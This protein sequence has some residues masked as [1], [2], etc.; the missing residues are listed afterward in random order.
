MMRNVNMFGEAFTH[1]AVY[2]CGGHSV[3]DLFTTFKKFHDDTRTGGRRSHVGFETFKM[4][5][6]VL[7]IRGETKCGLSS[8]YIH[9]R[10]QTQVFVHMMGRVGVI[11]PHFL[12]QAK[13]LVEEW[14][15][16]TCFVMWE[17]SKKHITLD[18]LDPC[19]CSRYGLGG[20]CDDAM[21]SHNSVGCEKCSSCITFFTTKV[22]IFLSILIQT[23]SQ[24][25][26]SSFDKM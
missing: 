21:H 16:M 2:E 25:N 17:Y 6:K 3:E 15:T 5:M 20:S 23:S 10:Y 22:N 1:L 7:T 18:D 8:Y 26:L 19:H 12:E 9:L 14:S 24:H 4:I 11:C 13:A